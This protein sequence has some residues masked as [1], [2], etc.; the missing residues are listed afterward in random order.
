MEFQLRDYQVDA[1]R[2]GVEFMLDPRRKNG[3]MIL[4]TGSGKS[5]V[6]SGI[7]KELNTPVLVLQPSREILE[8]NLA[9]F[10]SYGIRPGIYSAS[11]GRKSIAP[12]TLAMI[13]SIAG[14][15]NRVSKAALFDEFDHIL[16]DECSLV[17]PK[18]GLYRNFLDELG[19][20][21]VLG[22]DATPYRLS[23]DSF[24][25]ILKF[26]TR[27]RPRVFQEVVYWVQNKTLFDQGYLAKLEYH[28]VGGFDRHA[29]KANSTGADF[30]ERA[31]QLHFFQIGFQDKIVKVVNRLMERGRK[32][33]L[34]FCRFIREAQYVA[35][36]ILGAC[37]VT[38]DTPKEERAVII[39]EFRNGGIKVLVNVG[40]LTVGADFPE[41]ESVVLARP[42]KSLRLYYQMVGRCVRPH[43]DKEAA[44]VI[45]MC[46]LTDEFG[47]V[48]SL[49]LY[50]EGETKWAVWGKPGGEEER[51]LTNVY[52]NDAG[53]N[54]CKRCG[55]VILFWARHLVTNNAAPMQRP[56]NGHK[57]N[58]AIRTIEN[59]T[60]YEIVGAGE[61][62]AEYINHYIVCGKQT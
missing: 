5:L 47:P 61:P 52:L 46:G 43:P 38:A 16:I 33:A 32:N 12:I 50:V 53:G 17:N 55:Q 59:K 40:V 56:A 48:E 39:S 26:L 24:G 42:T 13:G 41:L 45:D 6:I 9:K 57:P 11:M 3:I 1:V 7:A 20:R 28:K 21:V 35:E 58:I 31:L 10:H 4:P 27:T 15:K 30:D 18:K 34:V 51:Q 14:N 29:V 60:K 2:A 54:R 36:Q 22:L 8:Q 62:D 37:L 49:M 23:S 19:D 25:T 44:W